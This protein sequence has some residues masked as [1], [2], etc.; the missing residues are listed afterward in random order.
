MRNLVRRLEHLPR[1]NRGVSGSILE[2][3]EEIV[4]TV[5]GLGLPQELRLLARL[6]QHRRERANAARV[7]QVT[8]NV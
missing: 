8:R 4:M 1:A 6:H 3:L 7:R 5:A 2:G